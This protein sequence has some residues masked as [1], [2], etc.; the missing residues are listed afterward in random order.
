MKNLYDLIQERNAL[1]KGQIYPKKI[2]GRTY[3]YHQ[4]KEGFKSV[5]KIVKSDEISELKKQI[6]KRIQIESEINEILKLGNKNYQISNNALNLTGDVMEGNKVVASFKNGECVSLRKD[7]APLMIVRKKRLEPFLKTRVID[8]GRTNSRLLK[9]ALGIKTNEDYIVSLY[10]YAASVSDNYW[11]RPKNSKL[12]YE[13]ISFNNDI[14]FSTSLRGIITLYKEK[15]TLTPEITTVGSYEKGWRNINGEW[16]LYKVGNKEEIF[17]ELLYSKIFEKLEIPTAHYEYEKPFIKS[18][19]FAINV[20][21]EPMISFVDDND[22]I[23]EIFNKLKVVNEKIGLDYLRLCFFDAVLN[24]VDRH[25][26]NYGLLRDRKSGNIISLAPNFDNNLSLISRNIE[27][28]DEINDGIIQ[29][30]VSK[31][32]KYP[33]LKNDFKKA[34]IPSLTAEIV[35]K[36]L[37]EIEIKFDDQKVIFYIIERFNYLYKIIN[38]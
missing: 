15:N 36:C 22:D 13:D 11:F 24:N 16:W 9:K 18:K 25:N 38:N 14:F 35:Q 10:S 4:Y 32:K 12:K 21:F 5:I 1:P 17:S 30:F 29:S 37:D 19:N 6:E 3:F 23:F 27:C 8:S 33:S 7:L 26:E 31:L 28:L 2:K 34:N 20:N